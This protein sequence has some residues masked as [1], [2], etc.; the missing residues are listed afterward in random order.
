MPS[1]VGVAIS[2]TYTRVECAVNA[3]G[4]H[5]LWCWND[6][7]R[8]EGVRREGREEEGGGEG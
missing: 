4:T 7:D 1:E 8:E 2:D 6:K 5:H 3:H